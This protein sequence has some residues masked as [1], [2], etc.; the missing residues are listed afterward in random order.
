[1][2]IYANFRQKVNVN[3]I[4]VIEKLIEEEIGFRGWVFIENDR[5]Y[6]GFEVS[7][8]CHSI[9]EKKEISKGKYEYIMSLKNCLN[10]LKN[11]KNG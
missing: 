4:D 5:Y 7:A 6:R 11:L 8:G 1:M 2:E 3:P 10:Y 9:D